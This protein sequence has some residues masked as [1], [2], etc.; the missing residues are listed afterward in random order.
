MD[1]F[2]GFR[3]CYIVIAYIVLKATLFD[4][5]LSTTV[6]Y[7][8]L[9]LFLMPFA[10]DY[11]GL[12]PVT[13]PGKITKGIGF[14][15]SILTIS[16]TLAFMLY[17]AIS[18]KDGLTKGKAVNVLDFSVPIQAVW[19]FCGLW[20]IFAITDWVVYSSGEEKSFREDLRN[21]ERETINNIPFS[22][23]V[24]YYKEHGVEK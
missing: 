16:F 15:A 23:R 11:A 19:I 20:L 14:W 9:L 8:L 4:P 22:Q 2:F 10:F 17:N 24:E 6:F 7:G 12:S 13:R 18:Q 21:Q 3:V 5:N 1:K